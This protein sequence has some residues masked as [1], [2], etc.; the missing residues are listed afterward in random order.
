M[1]LSWRLSR[2]SECSEYSALIEKKIQVSGL[3]LGSSTQELTVDMCDISTGL[4]VGG[5]KAND[6]EFPHMGA[7]GYLNLNREL[8]FAC[9]AALISERF[10]V[11]AAHC[12]RNG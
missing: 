4:I 5:I 7:I 1:N 3:S 2:L 8:I 10:L 12:R 11:T 6:H 9:G